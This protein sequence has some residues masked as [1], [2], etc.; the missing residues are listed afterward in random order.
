ML[1]RGERERES[2]K[3]KKRGE[4]VCVCETESSLTAANSWHTLDTVRGGITVALQT[5][6]LAMTITSIVAVGSV[7]S[8][9]EHTAV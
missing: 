5:H 6:S 3:E 8:R 4:R 1:I 9:T 2:E 7:G